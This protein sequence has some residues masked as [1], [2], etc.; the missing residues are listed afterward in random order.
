MTTLVTVAR[1]P[2][3]RVDRPA[4]TA[5]S[6]GDLR[7]AQTR[8]QGGSRTAG[9]GWA[10]RAAQLRRRRLAARD[11]K[12]CLLL[13]GRAR[14]AGKKTRSPPLSLLFGGYGHSAPHQYLGDAREIGR[15]DRR[16]VN[17]SRGGGGGG[18]GGGPVRVGG[19]FSALYRRGAQ[20]PKGLHDRQK[21]TGECSRNKSS[22]VKTAG[23]FAA[24]GR[25][26][27]AIWGKRRR[28]RPQTWAAPASGG[29]AIF[30]SSRLFDPVRAAAS[31]GDGPPDGTPGPQGGASPGTGTDGERW[32][33][34]IFG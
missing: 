26:W 16:A 2:R 9:Q 27:A 21:S 14:P 30:G 20:P 15:L 7:A 28:P 22:L 5:T 11:R 24:R 25:R 32:V 18:G 4:P 10:S 17:R 13:G 3:G 23:A 34:L 6:R 31:R 8:T 33:W 19:L 1:R 12:F 29:G